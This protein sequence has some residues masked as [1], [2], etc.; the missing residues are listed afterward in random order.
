MALASTRSYIPM[1][2]LVLL[3]GAATLVLVAQMLPT[4]TQIQYRPHAVER[5]G[6][7]AITARRLVL[8][9][10]PTKLEVWY[11]EVVNTVLFVCP[12]SAGVYCAFQPVQAWQDETGAWPELTAFIRPCVQVPV[13]VQRD[14]YVPAPVYVVVKAVQLWGSASE[15]EATND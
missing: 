2:F 14:G 7:D 11:S 1:V 8:N 5:H 9:C 3:L 10:D 4:R 12:D 13:V 15:M 6:K